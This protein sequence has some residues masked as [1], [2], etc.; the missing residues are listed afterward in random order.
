MTMR[1]PSDNTWKHFGETNPYFGVLTEDEFDSP[2]MDQQAF[3]K[4]FQSGETH[5][6]HV[7]SVFEKLSTQRRSYNSILDFGCG[8]GRLVIP[9]SKFA[10]HVTGIDVSPGM[11]KEAATNLKDFGINNVELIESNSL[12]IVKDRRFD[13]VHTYIV[14]QHIPVHIGYK[15]IQSL[16][17]LIAANGVGMIHLTYSNE[18]SDW[19]N[20]VDAFKFRHRWFAQLKNII[21]FKH[22]NT[23]YMQMNNYNLTIVY[24]MIEKAGFSNFHVEMTNHGGFRGASFYLVRE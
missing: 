10:G 13:L 24:R 15:L 23:P 22:P 9:F 8:T 17:S 21:K 19:K 12:E 20:K 3:N 16:L 11:L 14:L 6:K 4:F 1:I 18:R 5:V 2:K 7:L